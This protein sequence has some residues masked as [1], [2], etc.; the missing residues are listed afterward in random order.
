ED[1]TGTDPVIAHALAWL[2]GQ[3]QKA[4][5]A[6]CIYATA[7]F[8]RVDDLKR[9]FDVLVSTGKNF[10]FSVTTY[11][12]TMQHALRVLPGG[13]VEPF[14]PQWAN[15]RSQDLEE[16]YHDAAQFYWGR[17]EAFR[18]G[19]PMFGTNSIAIV[20][21]RYRVQDIDTVEDWKQAELIYAAV[22]NEN[23]N[24]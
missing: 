16:A 24:D 23:R 8:I 10:A 15:S 20:L 4:E 12:A 7:P 13:G 22:M 1:H 3:G 17:A 11:A 6:C 2:A 18:A 14:F 21:P 5:F 19:L 9:S